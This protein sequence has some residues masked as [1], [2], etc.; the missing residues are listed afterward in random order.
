M[1]LTV[2]IDDELVRAVQ[3]RAADRGVTVS[4]QVEEAVR[5]GLSPIVEDERKPIT[6]LCTTGRGG[7]QPGINL[8][9]MAATLDILDE[10]DAAH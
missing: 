8:D 3:K 10:Y 5:K 4:A 7:L 9:N 1:Q 2:E 6:K